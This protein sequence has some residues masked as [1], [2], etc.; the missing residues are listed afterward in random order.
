MRFGISSLLVLVFV[1][2]VILGIHQHSF[3]AFVIGFAA[4]GVFIMR[5]MAK[6]GPRPLVAEDGLSE[7][8]AYLL[9]NFLRERDVDARVEAGHGATAVYLQTTSCRVVVAA[10]QA[11][12]TAELLREFR[13]R[14][15][16]G[17][18]EPPPPSPNGKKNRVS[19]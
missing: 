11:E 19:E 4:L 3:V 1:S 6:S 16:A 8:D 2:A 12:R 9:S 13:A 17:P 5:L 15:A 18:P 7:V 14:V 10:D